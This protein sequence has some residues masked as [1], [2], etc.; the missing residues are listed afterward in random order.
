MFFGLTFHL[1]TQ[2]QQ[3]DEEPVHKICG[4]CVC[5]LINITNSITSSDFNAFHLC[6]RTKC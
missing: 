5:V 1:R 4:L 6:H 2:R 3:S